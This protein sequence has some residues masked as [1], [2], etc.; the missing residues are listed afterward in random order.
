MNEL[1]T[2]NVSGSEE[3]LDSDGEMEIGLRRRRSSNAHPRNMGPLELARF[4]HRSNIVQNENRGS[5]SVRQRSVVG[6]GTL[7]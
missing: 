1:E 3:A 5:R 4:I 2:V 6:P 7:L